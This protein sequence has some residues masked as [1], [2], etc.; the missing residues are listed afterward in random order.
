M[1]KQ[2]VILNILF[3]C[4]ILLCVGLFTAAGF[5]A[6]AFLLPCAVI[7]SA[8]M[9]ASFLLVRRS[10]AYSD[11]VMA[12]LSQLISSISSLGSVPVTVEYEDS[13]LSKLQSQTVK[14]TE[15][16]I[17]QNRLIESEKDEIKSL[18]SDISHQLK[19][20]VAA[21]HT[22]GELLLESDDDKRR[23]E[24]LA[25]FSSAL[26][27]LSFLTDNMVKLSRL[28]SGII[29]INP[30]PAILNNTIL[31]AVKQVY[32][33]ASDK[34]IELVF[35]SD[36]VSVEL[37]HDEKWSEE[38]IFNILDNAVKYTPSGGKVTIELTPLEMFARLDISDTGS[39][40]E[41]DELPKVFGRFYRGSNAANAEGVGIGLYLA[42]KIIIEQGGYIKAKSDSDGTVFSMYFPLGK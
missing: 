33:K 38:A 1:K 42:R 20:P 40:I 35:D 41:P 4:I 6:S 36:K 7:C 3:I 8:I 14:L 25:A 12:Q 31:G 23:A 9:L 11:S 27:K 16:L 2:S 5:F 17:E 24:Y 18:I 39:G 19:T 32:R 26:D 34:D 21:L 22:Y 10:Y 15:M 13:L 28:E 30:R 37:I 29:A